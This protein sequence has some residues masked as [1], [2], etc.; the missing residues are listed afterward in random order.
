MTAAIVLAGGLGTRLRSVVPDLPKPMALVNDKPFLSYLLDYWINQGVLEF[1]L[2]VGYRHQVIVDWFGADY[3]GV[4]IRYVIEHEQ[5]GTGG[6][7]ALAASHCVMGEPFILLNGDTFFAV[8]L[9]ELQSFALRSHADICL[10]LFP[11]Y[12]CE[13]FM[14]VGRDTNGLIT[15][16]R[17]E[18]TNGPHLA[19]GGV[20]WFNP[21]M[22]KLVHNV[23]SPCSL[24]NDLFPAWLET[25]IR[26]TGVE[27]DSPFIDIGVPDD[28]HRAGLVVNQGMR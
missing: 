4:P 19:N 9:N 3:R 24:E 13:R 14:G 10:S 18:I 15:S 8:N 23:V 7:L 20:Y 25:G 16:L 5:Q 12:D 11:T 21:S 2:S 17:S 28:Y 26:I 6:G 1:F 27:F 22:L